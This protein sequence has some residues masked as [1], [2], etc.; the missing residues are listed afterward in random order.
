MLL[1]TDLRAAVRAGVEHGAQRS[2]GVAREQDTAAA[3]LAGDE[4]AGLGQFG[5][6]AEIE[7]AFVEDPR[8]L[9][10]E[11]IRIDKGLARDLEYLLFLVDHERGIHPLERV[12]RCLSL[13]GSLFFISRRPAN[14]RRAIQG[15]RATA[16]R[17]TRSRA[18]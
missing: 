4:V 16:W 6:V 14:R 9:G 8:A 5:T 13:E 18:G 17:L 10:L 2:L 11:N 12:H 3:D 7:P 15:Q 1:A